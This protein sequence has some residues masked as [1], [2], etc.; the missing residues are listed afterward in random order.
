MIG[1]VDYDLQT[2]TSML[3]TPPNLEIMKLATYY[4]EEKNMFCRLVSLKETELSSYN[5]IYFFS[6]KDFF[7]QIPN[8][9]KRADNVLFGGTAFTNGIY[10]PFKNPIIDYTIP[11]TNIYKEFLKQKYQ[12]G[13][14]S[15]IINNI[16]DDTYYRCYAGEN[17]LPLPPV[18]PRK[19]VI[20]YDKDFFY[21]DWEDILKQIISHKPASIIRLHPIICK[22]LKQFFTIRNFPKIARSTK[23]ILDLNIPLKE[24]DYMFKEYKKFFLSDITINSN[25][26]ITL[27]GNFSSNLQYY[28]D[29][30]YKINLLYSFWSRNIP[31]KIYY[32]E[33]SIGY[34]D[35][36]QSLSKLVQTW[37]Y[38]Y[39]SEKTLLERITKKS[40]LEH[41]EY[42][43]YKQLIKI[44]P[45]ANDLFNQC[46]NQLSKRGVWRL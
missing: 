21:S 6:E 31:I 3:L 18:L 8:A 1:L 5:K 25:I 32:I 30:I 7:P 29:F 36:I 22:T 15:K 17:K 41:P 26:F 43:A 14:K 13:I 27:G 42:I 28:K 11:R 37:S 24:V 2:S 35:I 38:N 34:N 40:K 12:D 4:M 39:K 46:Y 9:F 19:H 45:N 44:Y 10:K 20:L 16:L 23:I 33:P